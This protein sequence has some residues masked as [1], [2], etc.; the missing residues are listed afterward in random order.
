MMRL[1]A[2]ER[3]GG[4]L[5]LEQDLG[6]FKAWVCLQCGHEQETNGKAEV[7]RPPRIFA[8]TGRTIPKRYHQ[9]KRPNR[10]KPPAGKFQ[11]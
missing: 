1:K 2:C 11:Q 5:S 9:D 4:D 7:C 3:C 8:S 10:N 6:D